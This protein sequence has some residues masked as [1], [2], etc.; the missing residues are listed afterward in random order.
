MFRDNMTL[1]LG[2]SSPERVPHGDTL[3]PNRTVALVRNRPQFMR[4]TISKSSK[5]PVNAV[6][7][8]FVHGVGSALY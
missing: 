7:I 5:N 3:G 4:L 2:R 1:V 8:L 6:Q